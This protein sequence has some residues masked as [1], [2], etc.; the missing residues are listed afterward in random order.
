[1]VSGKTIKVET[2]NMGR[3][4]KSK[5]KAKKKKQVFRIEIIYFQLKGTYTMLR[6]KTKIQLFGHA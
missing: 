4:K 3:Q 2:L 1:M 5:E 6:R